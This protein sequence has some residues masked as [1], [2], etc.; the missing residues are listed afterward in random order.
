VAALAYRPKLI[1]VDEITAVLDIVGRRR[2]MA[3]LGEFRQEGA[4]IVF[5]TNILEGL[6]G[7]VTDLLLLQEGRAQPV[8]LVRKILASQ[9]EADFSNKVADL[10]EVA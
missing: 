8:D 10:L 9:S 3:V 7:S 5:A 1:I 6:H 2:L 4:A